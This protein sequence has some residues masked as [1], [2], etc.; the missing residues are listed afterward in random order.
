[1]IKLQGQVDKGAAIPTGRVPTLADYAERWL[2]QLQRRPST[3]RRYGELL[4]FHIIPALG[5]R[6]PGRSRR[7]LRMA[8]PERARA[9]KNRVIGECWKVEASAGAVRRSSSRPCLRTPSRCLG[10]HA[11][12]TVQPDPAY[13]PA[14]VQLRMLFE[15]GDPARGNSV[16][17]PAFIRIVRSTG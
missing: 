3:V 14:Q 6:A 8:L 15:G 10:E 16:E 9:R 12:L 7:L 17:D 1:M 4:K 11:E 2:D 5:Q 13:S